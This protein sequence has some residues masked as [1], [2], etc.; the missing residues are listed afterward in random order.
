MVFV[1]ESK[2]YSHTYYTRHYN[3]A[4][5]ELCCSSKVFFRD[6]PFDFRV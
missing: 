2:C 1:A 6:L 5:A 4:A 3:Q